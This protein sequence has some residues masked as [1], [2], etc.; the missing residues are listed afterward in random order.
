M[1]LAWPAL[2]SDP[3]AVLPLA[4]ICT[5]FVS[6]GAGVVVVKDSWESVVSEVVGSCLAAAAR[7]MFA[8]RLAPE[9]SA[10]GF[11]VYRGGRG[12][13]VSV[14]ELE[15]LSLRVRKPPAEEFLE[16]VPAGDLLERACAL[17]DL[18]SLWC[19][20]LGFLDASL[21]AGDLRRLS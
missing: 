11:G 17:G 15:S 4:T 3:T 5:L 7:T 9:I 19:L 16:I 18:L 1:M 6:R 21:G 12:P 13:W 8:R 2:G 14:S 20:V 10:G